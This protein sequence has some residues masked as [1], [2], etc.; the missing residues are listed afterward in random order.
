MRRTIHYQIPTE[1]SGRKISEFLHS[2]GFSRQLL[3]TMRHTKDCIWLNNE[4]VHMNHTFSTTDF[5]TEDL[6]DTLIVSIPETNQPSNIIPVD[7][8]FEILYEDEDLYVINKPAGMPIHPSAS[9]PKNALANGLAYRH[10]A[11]YPDEPFVFRCVNRLDKDTSGLTILAKNPLSAGILYDAVKTRQVERTYFALVD[12]GPSL[13]DSGTITLPISR[14]E[15]SDRLHSIRRFVDEEHG[16]CA[17]THY[18]VLSRKNQIALLEFHLETGRT[19]Q[20]RVHMSA[21]G[22]PLLGDRI[23]NPGENSLLRQALHAGRLEFTHPITGE[24]LSF[25]AEIP[26]DMKNLIRAHVN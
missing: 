15:A 9:N 5:M 26:E 1:Y 12:D 17:I 20:I 21:I 25:T 14:E 6:K 13:P 22:F 16:A 4:C 3:T 11:L 7:L 8:P 23:Y 18:R 24:S 10:R 19:H 2:Q